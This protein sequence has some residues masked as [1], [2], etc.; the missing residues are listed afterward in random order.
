MT[1]NRR[2]S[3]PWI[4]RWSRPLLGTIAVVGALLTAYLTITKLTGAQVACTGEAAQAASNCNDVLNSAY[5]SIFGLPLPLFGF[6]AYGG[7]AVFALAPLAIDR[8]TN[9]R[10]R[11]TWEDWS[12]LLLLIGSTSMAVFSS[13]LMYLLAFK[14]NSV[15]FYCI[16][17]A[18]FSVSLFVLTVIG[19]EWE[20]LG[21]MLFT[22]IIVA[23]V[24]LF[25]TLGIYATNGPSSVAA[26]GAIPQPTTA[27]QPPNGWD[28]TTTSG[29]A[30]IALAQ[31]LSEIGAK[32]YGAFW[33]PHCYDQKQLFGKQAFGKINYIECAPEGKNPQPEACRSA[34]IQSFPTWE[35]SGQQ[36]QGTQT[37]EALAQ[38]SGYTGPDNFKYN[39]PGR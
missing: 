2:R 4:Y 29:E 18:L 13:Y 16:G 33:C 27:P 6:L 31:H 12:W 19:R 37:L 28:I 8:E 30:E 23:V 3:L 7:M 1:M 38:L 32:K 39:L 36:H 35:I 11:K 20:D 17:S 34:G 21:Q 24:T 9:R 14:L 22:I 26:G 5:A 25:G 15:C 10:S